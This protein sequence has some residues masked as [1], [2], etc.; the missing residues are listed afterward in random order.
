MAVESPASGALRCVD[1]VCHGC[2]S[3][4]VTCAASALCPQRLA[5]MYR[6]QVANID[7]FEEKLRAAEDALGIE[8]KDRIPVSYKRTGFFGKYVGHFFGS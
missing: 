5:L 3:P 4:F 7:R 6:M 8:G 2:R 1:A